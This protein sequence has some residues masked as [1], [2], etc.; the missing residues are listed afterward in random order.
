MLSEPSQSPRTVKRTTPLAT[1]TVSGITSDTG[2]PQRYTSPGQTSDRNNVCINP[3]RPP[4]MKPYS[5][6]LYNN[7]YPHKPLNDPYYDPSNM[8][9]IPLSYPINLPY[10]GNHASNPRMPYT[11]PRTGADYTQQ[12]NLKP[13]NGVSSFTPRHY[14][15]RIPVIPNRPQ[16]TPTN[17]S[18]PNKPPHP[19]TNA[20]Y[21]NPTHSPRAAPPRQPVNRYDS[22]YYSPR[23]G[24]WQYKMRQ[25]Q[26]PAQTDPS[27]MCPA[28][29]PEDE[30]INFASGAKRIVGTPDIPR[31]GVTAS[32]IHRNIPS[33][34]ISEMRQR[35]NP[36]DMPRNLPDFRD[37]PKHRRDIPADNRLG[38]PTHNHVVTKFPL[39][40]PNRTIYSDYPD[41]ITTVSDSD[42]SPVMST[43]CDSQSSLA[44][45]CNTPHR[46]GLETASV[47]SFTSGA[48]THQDLDSKIDQVRNLLAVIDTED[49]K[50][51]AQTLF[52]I[53]NSKENCQAMRLTGCL[54]LLI[55]L[56]H[57]SKP[58][59]PRVAH[60]VRIRSAQAI[61]NIIQSGV[62]DKRGKRELRVL[63]L[64]EV[65]RNYCTEVRYLRKVPKSSKLA[66][67]YNALAALMKLSFEEDHRVAIGDLGGVEAI[68]EFLELTYVSKDGDHLLGKLSISSEKYVSISSEKYSSMHGSIYSEKYSRIIFR[69]L[70]FYLFREM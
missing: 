62:E 7:R 14:R 21:Y 26:I 43:R 59:D 66:T 24:D 23:A 56:Q 11:A 15:P 50:E 46:D 67:L 27:S 52:S 41:D 64:I 54:P 9:A 19:Y 10:P 34:G 44:V 8:S 69:E 60:E 1:T 32:G 25:P 63:Q 28:D 42:V 45:Y 29:F 30:V 37:A 12:S 18:Y 2:P 39:N 53:S 16:I 20:G 65:V 17:P 55:Q 40:I 5:G 36:L 6:D 38:I 70:W 48:S 22:P 68:G 61:R 57:K 51:T 13:Y 4:Q 33:S 47:M 3:S 58:R 49:P 35:N 31:G